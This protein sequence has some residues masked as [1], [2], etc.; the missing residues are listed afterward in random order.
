MGDVRVHDTAA[1]LEI[2]LQVAR[3]AGELLV[4]GRPDDADLGVDTKTSSTDVVTEMD[5]RSE[6]LIVA[7]IKAARPQDGFL[8]EEGAVTQST[9]GIT[10]VI[11]PIDGTVNYLYRYPVWAVSIAACVSAPGM[12]EDMKAIVGVVHA[13]LLH[14]TWS[15]REGHGSFLRDSLGE[16]RLSVRGEDRLAHALIATGFAYEEHKRRIH[17]QTAA[18]LLPRVR[19]IRRP[20]SAALDICNVAAGRVDGYYERGTH[21]W[22]R[23]A[24]ALIAREAGVVL[25]GAHGAPES[26]DLAIATNPALFSQLHDALIEC[27]A[28]SSY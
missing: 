18:A 28:T 24:A 5:R 7:A 22:D 12:A 23:A 16:H 25:G 10:W 11:D 19:D 15:A 14:E 9:S 26:V 20:G 3:E 27:G 6:Q 21:A 17:G 8:G 2:A 13:P 1:L 4:H